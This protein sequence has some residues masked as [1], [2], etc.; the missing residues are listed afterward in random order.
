MLPPARRAL[1]IPTDFKRGYMARMGDVIEHPVSG[2]TMVF[3]WTGEDTDGELLQID[4]FVREGGAVSV[5]HIHPEQEERF[6]VKR[7]EMTIV[8]PTEG[9]THAG[10]E[11]KTSRGSERPSGRFAFGAR[12]R[13]S[14][15]TFESA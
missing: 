2:E 5:E 8:V 10:G 15:T 3:L 9:L 13:N 11:C 12:D 14:A 6:I 1:P 4:L 7:G